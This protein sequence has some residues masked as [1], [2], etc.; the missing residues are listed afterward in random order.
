MKRNDGVKVL[1]MGKACLICVATCCSV[2]GFVLLPYRMV[3]YSVVSTSAQNGA[4]TESLMG[5]DSGTK[6]VSG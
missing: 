3:P 6:W 1:W 5:K 4:M 2:E